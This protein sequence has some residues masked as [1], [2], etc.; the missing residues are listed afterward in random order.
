MNT[1]D[2]FKALDNF[3]KS[4]KIILGEVA[5]YGEKHTVTISGLLANAPQSVQNVWNK[6]AP[7]FHQV[8]LQSG[9]TTGYYRDLKAVKLD[10]EQAARGSKIMKE[11]ETVFHEY[12]H[13]IDYILNQLY[14]N[15]DDRKAFSEVYKGGL[16]GKAVKKEVEMHL[17]KFEKEL[18]DSG[19]FTK[20]TLPKRQEIERLFCESMMKKFTDEQ[21]VFDS[22]TLANISDMF[23]S[24]MKFSIQP[25]GAGHRGES[26]DYWKYRDNSKE[27]FAE[28][29]SATIAH[30][31]S[32]KQIKKYFPKSYK[33]FQQMLEVV[34]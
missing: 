33:I 1:Y 29:F 14:G 16:L 15:G 28:M 23:E 10:I 19:K 17:R 22:L 26:P 30:Q 2:A 20:D 18:I 34:S 31:E 12:G 6:C 24:G 9:E 7:K 32:L 3:E 5:N 4:G 8:A 13:H 11:Y 25:F 27:A 21:G